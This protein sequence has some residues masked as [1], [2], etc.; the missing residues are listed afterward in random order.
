MPIWNEPELQPNQ[1]LWGP[2]ML[3]I[4]TAKTLENGE[5]SAIFWLSDY[6]LDIF[7][8]QEGRG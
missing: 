1:F 3:F 4:E 2:S 5:Y 7:L 6:Y 8:R